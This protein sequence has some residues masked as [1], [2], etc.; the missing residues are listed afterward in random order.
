MCSSGFVSP[1]KHGNNDVVIGCV[2]VV[3]SHKVNEF[4]LSM[5]SSK[6]A[7]SFEILSCILRSVPLNGGY[8][9]IALNRAG[10]YGAVMIMG[11]EPQ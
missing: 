6:N 9:A 5:Q 1:G 3:C 2:P 11:K 7:Q 10:P 4:G 8:P